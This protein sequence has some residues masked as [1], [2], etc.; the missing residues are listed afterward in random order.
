LIDL[1]VIIFNYVGN[2]KSNFSN[3]LKYTDIESVTNI[4]LQITIQIS[5][6]YRN[7]IVV[8]SSLAIFIKRMKIWKCLRLVLC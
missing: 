8:I 2:Y 7:M 3:H 1:K 4:K 5:Y 6:S